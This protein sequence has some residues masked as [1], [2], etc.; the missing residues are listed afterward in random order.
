MRTQAATI[1]AGVVAFAACALSLSTASAKDDPLLEAMKD[2]MARS[3]DVL[4]LEDLEKP[5]YS[6]Y[7]VEDVVSVNVHTAFGAVISKTKDHRRSLRVDVRVG[8]YTLDNSEFLGGDGFG[9][10]G[11]MFPDELVLDDDY[12]ALRHDIWLATDIAYK[13]AL[14]DIAS[15]RA[16][17]KTR[18]QADEIPDFSKA[19]AVNMIGP[20]ADYR[21]SADKWTQRCRTLSEVFR[22]YPLIQESSV[23]LLLQ[24][25]TKYYVNSEGSVFRQPEVGAFLYARAATQAGDG[26]RLKNY[27]SFSAL[28]LDKMPSEEEMVDAVK[29]MAADLTA[30][31]EAPILDKYVGPVLISGDAAADLFAQVLAPELSGHRPP[32][33][34]AAQ[35]SIMYPESKLAGRLGR[36]VLPPFLTV[37]DDPTIDEFEGLPLIGSYQVDDQGVHA[38]A[39]TVVR[40]GTLETLLMSRRPMKEITESNGHGRLTMAGDVTAQI[41]NLIVTSTGGDSEEALKQ[42]LVAMCVDEGLDFGLMIRKF[43]DVQLTGREMP[44]SMM[45]L[46][47]GD[48]EG[49]V[50]PPL[51]AYRVYVDD[52]RE[53]LV[54]G[55]KLNGL[56]V[57]TLRDIV[58]TSTDHYAHSFLMS[59]DGGMMNIFAMFSG[60]GDMGPTGISASVVAP[61]VLF[62]EL[63]LRYEGGSKKKPATL[64]HPYFDN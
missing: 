1:L 31:A 34:E 28:D 3:I 11:G 43:D 29:S 25:G 9:F 24:A 62:E 8:D 37:V 39:V 19:D 54:R 21:L 17:K 50:S 61:S 7:V 57:R 42:Q 63:E 48:G 5:Y 35:M 16:L 58:A 59:S 45:A 53:E 12:D 27:V 36:K 2:E 64:A 14:E 40:E 4:R 26:M 44:T 56:G 52:G 30:L 55:L 38:R 6:Q 23:R 15:K 13:Q 47:G 18:T 51:L 22:N 20:K 10:G 46:M 41:A 33:T 32:M 60:I 49:P